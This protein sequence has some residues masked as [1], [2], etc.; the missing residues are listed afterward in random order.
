MCRAVSRKQ[1]VKGFHV[2]EK[3]TKNKFVTPISESRWPW[4]MVPDT[5]FSE[6]GEYKADLIMNLATA[7]SLANEVAL[8]VKE[9]IAKIKATNPAVATWQGQWPIKDELDEHD[10]PTGMKLVSFR[11][12]ASAGNGQYNFE[13]AVVD[14]HKNPIPKTIKLGNGT[15]MRI[16]F[17]VR[18]VEDNLNKCI[19]IKF[20]PNAAQIIKLVEWAADY[21]FEETDGY[22][23][24][25][26]PAVAPQGEYAGE[27]DDA[28][29]AT[30]AA[31]ADESIPF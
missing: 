23:V 15:I 16:S 11:Q 6:V 12:K 9:Q 7:K 2:D 22:S 20:H 17:Y 5:R 26:V 25:E 14:S 27:P 21:G 28:F 8:I 18:C 30:P 10:K 3:K 31:P 29:A 4:L 13:V 24:A 1:S 19:R